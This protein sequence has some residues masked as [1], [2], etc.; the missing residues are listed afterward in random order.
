[1]A[2]RVKEAAM[3][4]RT[5]RM[6]LPARHKPYFR[7]LGE[8]QHLGYRRSTVAGK[9]GTWLLRR[10]LGAGAYETH[11]LGVADD[12]PSA[13]EHAQAPLTFD[14]AQA[15]AR[16][17]ARQRAHTAC[18]AEAAERAPTVHRAVEEYVAHR[19][20]RG[21]AGRD[22]ELRLARH[23]V[24]TPLA[25]LALPSLTEA[26]FAAW[27]AGL[28]CGGRGAKPSGLPLAPA[29][30]ARVLNDLRAA[31]TSAARK[32]GL[33]ADALAAI[34]EGLRAPE[35]PNRA[36][37]K[38]VLADADVRR[39]VQAAMDF[40][41][42]FGDLVLVLAATGARFDQ[43]ARLTVADLQPDAGRVM[44]PASH[45]GRGAK[46]VTRIAVPLPDDVV[47]RLRPVA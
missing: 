19:K 16:A 17:L 4:T 27:R 5:A 42:D 25:D 36:R 2:K 8:G 1:M 40:D 34:R 45:K 21:P 28:R 3:G 30:V 46:Q 41:P 33:P 12:L 7:A 44:V 32:A 24:S 35:A 22:A 6:K 10:Y 11:V 26:D 15:A 43:A 31:L 20:S 47:A 9:A 37:E 39:V 13:T 14:Q 18:A 23:V 29:T 38:Q